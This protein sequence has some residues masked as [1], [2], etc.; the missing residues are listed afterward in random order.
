MVAPIA[1]LQNE[2]P[3]AGTSDNNL[4]KIGD[5]LTEK[6][7]NTKSKTILYWEIKYRLKLTR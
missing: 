7:A 4:A 1:I 2:I 3:T 6:V 5:V